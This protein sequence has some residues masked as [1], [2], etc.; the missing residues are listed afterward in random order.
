MS[1][2]SRKK[3]ADEGFGHFSDDDLTVRHYMGPLGFVA[4]TTIFVGAAFLIH[5]KKHV[6]FGRG[7][8]STAL[9]VEWL[10]ITA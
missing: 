7:P 2:P 3:K 5:F 9:V 10:F 6:S 8:A 4:A 1:C